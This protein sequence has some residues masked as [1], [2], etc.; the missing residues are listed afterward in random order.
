MTMHCQCRSSIEIDFEE[1]IVFGL[2][3]PPRP[4]YFSYAKHKRRAGPWWQ[5]WR[6][7]P[8]GLACNSTLINSRYMIWELMFPITKYT[9]SPQEWSL[10]KVL[11]CF[12]D[13]ISSL[14]GGLPVHM[15][16]KSWHCQK[17]GGG[18]WQ[19]FLEDLSTMHWGPSKVIIHHQT[20]IISPQ[21][22]ALIH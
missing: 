15:H 2:W 6:T 21:K 17:G 7:K 22:C 20:V 16:P 12:K 3:F 10:P 14:R 9:S 18:S 1:E 13:F 5:G 19:D 8:L 11:F 4:A